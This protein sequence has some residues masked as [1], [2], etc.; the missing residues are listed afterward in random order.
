MTL[1]PAIDIYD[2]KVVRLV[3]GDFNQR[4]IFSDQPA[5]VFTQFANEGAKAVHVVDLSGAKNPK[6]RQ[7]DLI[8]KMV[9]L[10]NTRIQVG[11]GIRSL[12]EIA[13]LIELGVDRVVL[14]SLVIT[15]PQTTR[16]A[17]KRWGPEKLTLSMDVRIVDDEPV[18][19]TH[20]WRKYSKARL[21]ELI[22]YFENYDLKRILCTDISVDGTLKGPNLKLY[23]SI[24]N[25][26]PQLELQASGGIGS[27]ADIQNLARIGVQSVVIGKALFAGKFSL[28]QA[29]NYDQ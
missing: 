2:G 22:N 1:Y 6:E 4:T 21:F 17:L 12:E 29:L 10:S 11:G 19:M 28:S 3:E 8:K 15:D 9:S 5:D 27:I 20:A 18:V 7:L 16:I 25:R 26:F 14:G 24:I 13:E 23:Q